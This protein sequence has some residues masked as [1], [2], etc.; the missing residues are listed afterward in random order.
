MNIYIN[1]II[2]ESAYRRFQEDIKNIR[3][4]TEVNVHIDSPG[5]NVDLGIA[6]YEH[7]RGMK[8]KVTTIARKAQSIAS[9]IF[10][11]GDERIVIEELQEPIL[12]HLPRLPKDKVEGTADTLKAY[13]SIMQS[14]EDKMI[15]IYSQYLPEMTREGIKTLLREDRGMTAS[16]AVEIGI[17]TAKQYPIKAVAVFEESVPN[18]KNKNIMKELLKVL[19]AFVKDNA[20]AK[21]EVLTSDGVLLEFP[22]VEGRE[23]QEGDLTSN[24]DGEYLMPNGDTWVIL[25]GKLDEIKEEVQE[26]VEEIEAEVEEETVVEEPKEDLAAMFE[27]FI[28]V[29]DKKIETLE[30]RIKALEDL[31]VETIKEEIDKEIVALK[32][33]IKGGGDAIIDVKAPKSWLHTKP[34]KIR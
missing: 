8:Q 16:E 1:G 33:S 12:V 21:Y 7:L 3:Q 2:D 10:L 15:D 24:A 27:E 20:V 31:N 26:E 11:A 9:I 5:G 14:K 23:P 34:N 25:E 18:N 30:G 32:S 29:M 13:A 4:S 17:A 19:T 28:K 22:E 6:I